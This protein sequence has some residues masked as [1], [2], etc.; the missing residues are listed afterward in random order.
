MQL[1][2]EKWA[3]YLMEELNLPKGSSA[4]DHAGEIA[5]RVSL[6]SPHDFEMLQN[7]LKIRAQKEQEANALAKFKQLNRHL[8]DHQPKDQELVSQSP[9]L[10]VS[11]LCLL[12]PSTSQF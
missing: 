2:D 1:K 5:H 10:D 12:L 8:F 3:R 6:M 9:R 7:R 11:C 4:D